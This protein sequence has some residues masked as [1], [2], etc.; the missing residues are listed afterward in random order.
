LDPHL[1]KALVRVQAGVAGC[2]E[3]QAPAVYALGASNEQGSLF[4]R[5]D[6]H[7]NSAATSAQECRPASAA[8][9]NAEEIIVEP[10]RRDTKRRDTN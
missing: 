6:A 2:S 5:S 10:Q 1:E 4:K 7:Q 3:K 9:W 8:L